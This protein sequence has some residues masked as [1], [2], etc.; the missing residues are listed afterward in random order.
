MTKDRMENIGAENE[1][2][3]TDMKPTTSGN[4][5]LGKVILGVAVAAAGVGALEWKKLG[6]KREEANVERLRKKG[7]AVYKVEPNDSD[8]PIDVDS[9]EI[10]E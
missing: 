5:K 3:G 6:K 2:N 7:Y 10:P 1:V 9:E 4:G 8:E